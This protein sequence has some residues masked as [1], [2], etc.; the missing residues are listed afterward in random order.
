M[1]VCICVYIY[2]SR[3]VWIRNSCIMPQRSMCHVGTWYSRVRILSGTMVDPFYTL[4]NA[5]DNAAAAD[6]ESDAC[7]EEEQ[8]S[9]SAPDKA[10]VPEDPKKKA[11]AKP[12]SK[13]MIRFRNHKIRL[14]TLRK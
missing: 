4:H 1:C 2:T 3:P 5:L 8:A 14:E 11:S 13:D 9:D 12:L 7:C 6:S 10:S